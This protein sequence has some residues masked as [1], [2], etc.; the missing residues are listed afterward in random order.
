MHMYEMQPRTVFEIRKLA[1]LLPGLVRVMKSEELRRHPV[2]GRI[3]PYHVLCYGNGPSRG[4][5]I[6]PDAVP[7]A[8]GSIRVSE[9]D[10][11]PSG[12]GFGMASLASEDQERFGQP[13]ADWYRSM[14][15]KRIIYG[16]ATT[17]VCFSETQY[18]SE[19]MRRMFGID[20][21]AANLDTVDLDP[22]AL[23]KRLSYRAEMASTDDARRNL[24]GMSVVTAEPYL[25]SKAV[26]AIVHD[27]TLDALLERHVGADGLAFLRQVFPEARMLEHLSEDALAEVIATRKEWVIKST[28]VETTACWGTRSTI[29]GRKIRQAQFERACRGTS[30]A[31]KTIGTHSVLQLFALSADFR[32]TWDAACAGDY[33]TAG[34][35]QFGLSQQKHGPANQEIYARVGFYVLVNTATDR[36]FLPDIGLLTLRPD[37]L[38]HGA[39]NAMFLPFTM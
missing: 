19:Q 21:V 27:T 15:A 34:S 31:N 25:D 24:T 1:A 23:I 2:W 7:L 32:S 3:I 13:F 29:I 9:L 5:I 4:H 33:R 6:R 28:D 12:L 14:D 10:F 37:E 17:T 35:E 8:D 20:I 11:V 26:L 38:V 22:G 18:Y 30:V 16:T 36:V 39:S